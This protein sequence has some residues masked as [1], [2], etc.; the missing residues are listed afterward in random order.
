MHS[1]EAERFD[2]ACDIGT[3]E[4]IIAAYK[5]LGYNFAMIPGLQHKTKGSSRRQALENL[6]YKVHYA[7]LGPVTE[8]RW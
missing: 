3:Y 7:P 4:S 8:V 6:G 1:P 5:Q 2:L